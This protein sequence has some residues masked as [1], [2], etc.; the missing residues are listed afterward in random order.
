V[1]GDAGA[2]A[3][4]CMSG[5]TQSCGSYDIGTLHCSGA[6]DCSSGNVCCGVYDLTALTAGTVC[7]P[8]PCMIAQF[9][10]TNEECVNHM[11][12]QGQTC[13]GGHL[14]LCGVQSQAP[15]NCVKDP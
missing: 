13:A 15:Y 7:Q 8:G 3:T 11:P 14:Y 2:D 4:Y 5:N 9:C 10:E 12:C 1:P 6:T